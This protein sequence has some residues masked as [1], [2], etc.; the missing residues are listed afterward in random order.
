MGR[1]SEMNVVPL[2]PN[3]SLFPPYHGREHRLAYSILESGA[4]ISNKPRVSK[5][6]QAY[7]HGTLTPIHEPTPSPQ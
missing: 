3:P 2:P 5:L 4:F 7:G 1:Q 6:P